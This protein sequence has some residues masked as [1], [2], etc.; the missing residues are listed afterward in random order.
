M[1]GS[2]VL[3]RKLAGR[4]VQIFTS[5]PLWSGRPSHTLCA[6]VSPSWAQNRRMRPGPFKRRLWHARVSLC[7]GARA[8]LLVRRP[9]RRSRVETQ[10]SGIFSSP[11]CPAV[12]FILGRS[13][14]RAQCTDTGVEETHV[15]G[16]LIDV[17]C[18]IATPIWLL[19]ACQRCK[20]LN[21]YSCD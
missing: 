17:G 16:K 5:A 8:L 6:P 13:H 10:P 14:E 18:Q 20:Q 7:G 19:P 11:F 12:P 2:Q 21:N 1:R 4:S 15:R 9:G 3:G